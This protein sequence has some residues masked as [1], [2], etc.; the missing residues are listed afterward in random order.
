MCGVLELG[1]R[2]KG[3]SKKHFGVSIDFGHIYIHFGFLQQEL[4]Y[5]GWV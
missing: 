5:L 4:I 3:Q 1:A 2:G